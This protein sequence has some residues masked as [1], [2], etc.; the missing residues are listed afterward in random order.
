MHHMAIHW[1]GPDEE[2]KSKYS[3][4]YP[5]TREPVR[6]DSL[7]RAISEALNLNGDT[8]RSADKKKTDKS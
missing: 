2:K 6:N 4:L 1:C 5:W 7:K 8:V 3:P